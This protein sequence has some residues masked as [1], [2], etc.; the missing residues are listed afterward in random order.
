MLSLNGKQT[1]SFGDGAIE[2]LQC[3]IKRCLQKAKG[4]EPVWT[5]KVPRCLKKSAFSH[6][7]CSVDCMFSRFR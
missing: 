1:F 3:L 5:E 4:H 2:Q 6:H 7:T